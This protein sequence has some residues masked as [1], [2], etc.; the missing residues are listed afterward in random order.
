MAYYKGFNNKLRGYNEFQFKI[1]EIYENLDDDSWKWFHYTK[2]I[3]S[4]LNYFDENIRICE[5]QPIGEIRKFNTTNLVYKD[6]YYTTN[7]IK[8]LRELDKNEIYEI[9]ENE[10]FPFYLLVSKLKPDFNILFK[11]KKKIRG[12]YCESVIERR[13]L[14][15]SE[16]KILLPKIWHKYINK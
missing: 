10:K 9:L 1:G 12:R 13:D 11:Y 16:K 15:I 8:I 6:I 3:S 7:K 2:K 14:S 4:T 5:I